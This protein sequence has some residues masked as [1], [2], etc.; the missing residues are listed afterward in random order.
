LRESHDTHGHVSYGQL[1][2]SV[3][4]LFVCKLQ[5]T[6]KALDQ[7]WK[8]DPWEEEFQICTKDIDPSWGWT[9]G[10]LKRGSYINIVP[11][12]I[13]CCKHDLH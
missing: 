10:G 3:I 6:L 5:S 4:C 7:A 12:K 8:D 11:C 13:V 9:I 1:F 2:T